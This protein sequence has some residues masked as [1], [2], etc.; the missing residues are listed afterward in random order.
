VFRKQLR[1]LRTRTYKRG[2]VL[3]HTVDTSAKT[4]FLCGSELLQQPAVWLGNGTGHRVSSPSTTKAVTHTNTL[5][6]KPTHCGA[7]KPHTMRKNNRLGCRKCS[8]W[9]GGFT[10]TRWVSSP[11]F[12]PVFY[13]FACF[14]RCFFFSH[15]P[16][17][18]KNSSVVVV[19]CSWIIPPV[20]T[21]SDAFL[22]RGVERAR[23]CCYACS[24][25]RFSHGRGGKGIQQYSVCHGIVTGTRT[26][27][28]KASSSRRQMIFWFWTSEAATVRLLPA[29]L[30][31]SGQP[32]W[33][34][35]APQHARAGE[36]KE[37]VWGVS[38][39][40]D[41]PSQSLRK[42]SEHRPSESCCRWKPDAGQWLFP[43]GQQQYYNRSRSSGKLN[44]IHGAM[45]SPCP[46]WRLVVSM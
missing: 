26:V 39:T 13:L 9:G 42:N 25:Q 23:K 18:P 8:Q 29:I 2:R 38:F 4:H 37:G 12:R 40:R 20:H 24:L 21:C 35:P 11:I 16:I 28:S 1:R 30:L 33:D 17:S 34:N 22:G 3:T 7:S 31:K 46:G 43:E 44:L 45:S 15:A 41:H 14:R 27:S 19:A 36:R 6:W 32:W 10:F 5:C